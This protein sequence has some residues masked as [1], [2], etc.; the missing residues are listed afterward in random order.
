MLYGEQEGDF[1]TLI[2]RCCLA[3]WYPL[4][5]NNVVKL[6]SL[7]VILF[8]LLVIVYLSF[9]LHLKIRTE[10]IILW[11]NLKHRSNDFY[12][13]NDLSLC[14]LSM[15]VSKATVAWLVVYSVK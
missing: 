15:S 8:H 14:S 6:S 5:W 11:R 13:M 12:N 9:A 4:W 2:F 1:V 3:H 7:A 10:C